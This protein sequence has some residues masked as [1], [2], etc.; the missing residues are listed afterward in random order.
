MRRFSPGRAHRLHLGGS[1]FGAA[2]IELRLGTLCRLVFAE[3]Q[4]VSDLAA[5][6]LGDAPV[7]HPQRGGVFPELFHLLADGFRIRTLRARILVLDAAETGINS[8]RFL[9]PFRHFL[10][11]ISFRPRLIGPRLQLLADRHELLRGFLDPAT[12]QVVARAVWLQQE[13]K[14][15]LDESVSQTV[16][17]FSR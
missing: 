17:R 15:R 7:N 2:P 14:K 8:N 5:Q 1:R 12:E 3:G 13:T 16:S 11:E 9:P 10:L 4:K 6:R